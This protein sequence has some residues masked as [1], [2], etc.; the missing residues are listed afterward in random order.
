M[1]E[2]FTHIKTTIEPY[3]NGEL[4]NS[5]LWLLTL[6]VA[7]FQ[8]GNLLYRRFN[9]FP[10]FHP[11]IIGATLV[12]I[13]LTQLNID[14]QSYFQGNQLLLFWL[15]P[16][17]VAL[18]IPLY[19]QLHL[20]RQMAVPIL[21]TVCSGACFAAASAAI[22]AWLLGASTT[23]IL[24]LAPKSVTTPIAISLADEIGGIAA[25]TAGAVAITAVVGISLGPWVFRL[26]KIDDPKIWGFCLGITAHG[27]G[28]ARAFEI[29]PTAGAFSSLAMCLTGALSAT[30]IPLAVAVIM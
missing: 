9:E 8:V 1:P 4:L 25:L 7:G 28:T 2:L 27:M 23:T 29:N 12:A 3:S 30:I 13:V 24:S 11:T 19:Q 18:A 20:I 10:L 5:P 17:T 14:Y 16:A 6:S 21:F 26:L 15:G 22:I